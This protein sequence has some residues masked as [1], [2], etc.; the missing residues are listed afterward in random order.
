M[1][2]SLFCN[3]ALLMRRLQTFSPRAF[4]RRSSLTSVHCWGWVHQGDHITS[5]VFSLRGGF[6]HWVFPLSSL[7]FILSIVRITYFVQGD[8]CPL[9]L[10]P[11]NFMHFIFTPPKYN[12]KGGCWSHLH[13]MHTYLV[14]FGLFTDYPTFNWLTWHQMIT[15]WNQHEHTHNL[16]Q[17][18]RPT[19]PSPSFEEA[20]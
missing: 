14:N 2:G 4:Q 10:G 1:T 13:N 19:K 8:L 9:F 6:S 12:L 7:R 18:R 5:P 16:L 15:L 17:S 11:Y 20:N 3:I